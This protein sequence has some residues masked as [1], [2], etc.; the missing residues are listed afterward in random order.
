MVEHKGEKM[1]DSLLR[2]LQKMFGF[3]ELS[4]KQ[5]YNPVQ[6]CYSFKDF[7]GE[8]TRIGE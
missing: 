2:Q 3:L 4:E 7:F 5:A 1:D 6:F 8:P